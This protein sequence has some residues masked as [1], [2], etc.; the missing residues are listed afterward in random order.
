MYLMYNEMCLYGSFSY[1]YT[2]NC[3]IRVSPGV[4]TYDLQ[5]VEESIHTTLFRVLLVLYAQ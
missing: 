2:V 4:M 5:R 3:L 1:E